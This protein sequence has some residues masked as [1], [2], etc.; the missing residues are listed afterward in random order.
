[1]FLKW[2]FLTHGCEN[3]M[4]TCHITV[5][6]QWSCRVCSR[7]HLPFQGIDLKADQSESILSPIVWKSFLCFPFCLFLK[8]KIN[9]PQPWA[10]FPR[11]TRGEQQGW[12]EGN[13]LEDQCPSWLPNVFLYCSLKFF[14]SPLFTAML[15]FPFNKNVRH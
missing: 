12:W 9:K 13:T 8:W 7:Y 6:I 5:A 2:P 4:F 1:M 15:L 11:D 10:V 14:L 3:E